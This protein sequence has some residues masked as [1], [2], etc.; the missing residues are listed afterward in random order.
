MGRLNGKVAI[1]TGSAHGIGRASAMVMAREGAKICVADING[2]GAR[3]VAEEIRRAGGEAMH[4]KVDI[5]SEAEI[6]AMVAATVA[7]YGGLDVIQNTAAATSPEQSMGDG[8]IHEADAAIWDKALTVTVR[9]TMLCCKHAITEMLKRGKGSVINISSTAGIVGQTFVPAYGAAKAGVH[10]ISQYV[11]TQYGRQGIRA[12]T[13]APGLI[14]T[15]T[16]E[17]LGEDFLRICAE[18]CVLGHIGEAEDIAHVAA[19]LASDEAKYLTG[20]HIPVDGGQ[21]MHTPLFADLNRI[22]GGKIDIKDR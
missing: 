21:I 16:T 6:K 18:N 8:L 7:A 10:S 12:N 5:A 4:F 1:V 22:A 14:M 17:K 2:E 20:Q 19:F 9:G 3:K 15:P 11:A 13:I